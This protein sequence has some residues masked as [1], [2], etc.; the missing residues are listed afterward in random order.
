M[1][2][3]NGKEKCKFWVVKKKRFC[4]FDAKTGSDYCGNHLVDGVLRVP[5]PLDPGQ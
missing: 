5:C 2:P 3:G 4:K 1:A